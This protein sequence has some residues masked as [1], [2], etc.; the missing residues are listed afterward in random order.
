M[1]RRKPYSTRKTHLG[2]LFTLPYYSASA[3]A[4]VRAFAST[5]AS[6]SLL[7]PLS[8]AG[9]TKQCSGKTEYQ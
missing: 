2:S 5:N 4:R 7:I 8:I 1:S 9:K 3:F 6:A